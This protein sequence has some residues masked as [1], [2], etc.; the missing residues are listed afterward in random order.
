MNDFVMDI[1]YFAGLSTD[2]GR[3]DMQRTVIAGE[4][5][6]LGRRQD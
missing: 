6:T 2:I 5:I 4:P 1:W 3:G